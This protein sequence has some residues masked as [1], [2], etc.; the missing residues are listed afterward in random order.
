ME[1]DGLSVQ[2]PAPVSSRSRNEYRV[3]YDPRVVGLA[4]PGRARRIA[5]LGFPLG[6]N[7]TR[8]L[9][10]PTILSSCWRVTVSA[11]SPSGRYT[12][13]LIFGAFGIPNGQFVLESGL[14]LLL[15]RANPLVARRPVL[16][17]NVNHAAVL[18]AVIFG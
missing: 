13:I 15:D 5:R 2:T 11:S 3:P 10:S 17:Q 4:S 9:P 12:G 1:C 6:L 8:T 16:K 14:T 18:H 7:S